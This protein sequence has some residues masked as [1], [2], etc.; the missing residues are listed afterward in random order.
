[1]AKINNYVDDDIDDDIDIDNKQD[2]Q[3]KQNKQNKQ[4]DDMTRLLNSLS[5]L[6]ETTLNKLADMKNMTDMKKMRQMFSKLNIDE[7]KLK[8]LKEKMEQTEYATKVSTPLTRD[9]LR[10]KLREKTHLMRKTRTMK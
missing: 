9:E 5:G 1:M 2:K 10:K 7:N 6:D 3:N 8:S 4:D